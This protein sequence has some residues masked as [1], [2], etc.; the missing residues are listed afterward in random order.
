MELWPDSHLLNLDR[1]LSSVNPSVSKHLGSG[2][3]YSFFLL[4]H[5]SPVPVT[6]RRE[7]SFL[8]LYL[9]SEI[10]G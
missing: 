6:P 3:L 10:R 7:E 2:V 9:V 5:Y 8:W 1:R 4:E